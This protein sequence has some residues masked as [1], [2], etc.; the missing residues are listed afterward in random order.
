M[1]FE[2]KEPVLGLTMDLG[3]AR[4]EITSTCGTLTFPDEVDLSNGEAVLEQAV[5]LL[6]SGAPALILDLTGCTFCDS[7][8][9]NVITRSQ[10]RATELGVPMWVVLPPRGIVRRVSDV[11]GLQRRVA[12]A[13]DVATAREALAARH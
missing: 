2:V 9:L 5:R 8:G 12:I 11:A 4:V 6:D 1:L 3:V 7:N 13:P 10:M